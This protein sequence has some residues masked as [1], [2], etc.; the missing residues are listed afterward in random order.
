MNKL[1]VATIA[2]LLTNSTANASCLNPNADTR[3]RT[4]CVAE[5]LLGNAVTLNEALLLDTLLKRE[6]YATGIGLA[7]PVDTSTTQT[8]VS[9]VLDYNTNINGGNPNRPLVLGGLE[10]TGDEEFLR[11]EGIVAGVGAGVNGRSIVGEGRYLDYGIAANYAYSPQHGLSTVRGSANLCSRNHIANQWYMDAC[12]D[13]TRL[14]RDLAAET[15]SGLSLSTAKLFTTGNGAYH[16]ASVGVRRY[17]AEA[18]QQNQIQLG[19]N[20]VRNR[21]A[22]TAI[23]A[24]F[25]ETVASQLSLR[26]S[27]SATV[28]TTVFNRALTATVVYS[29][30]D[31]GKLLGFERNDTTRSIN[32]SYGLTQNMSLNV[33]YRSIDSTIEYFSEQEPIVSVQFATLRF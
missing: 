32:I 23:N 1:F 27:V 3:L 12:G 24:A 16:S 31:G 25:G 5:T 11:K 15:N 29:Y 28:G 4:F 30:A 14:V 21:G 20:T 2:T 26:R 10:F 17:Y 33:G 19:W 9:P 13:T 6:G 22:Y 7:N 8:F 18:Y